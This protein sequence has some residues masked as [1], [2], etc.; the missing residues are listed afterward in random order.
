MT[1]YRYLPL[2]FLALCVVALAAGLVRE[3]TTPADPVRYTSAGLL[4]AYLAWIA[5][6]LRVTRRT[7]R[8]PHDDADSG[9]MYAYSGARLLV[10]VSCVLTPPP[11]P[12]W[13]P[14]LLVPAAVFAGGVGLRVAAVRTLGRFYSHR[15]R[16]LADHEIVRA[17]PYRVVR[18]PAYAGMIAAQAGFVAFFPSVL[19]VSALG[20][21]FLPVLAWRVLVEE[22]ALY[23]LP[24]YRDYASSR[25]RLVPAVW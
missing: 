16:T 5:L 19:S 4:A 7:A 17:G 11:W 13:S 2:V 21:V 23:R 6:E 9:T 18:H 20:L 12:D 14:L 24:G 22:R 1:V 8:E 15:V 10:V 3:L 25:K